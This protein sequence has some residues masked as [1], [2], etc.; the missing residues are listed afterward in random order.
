MQGSIALQR[1]AHLL[2]TP[3]SLHF[4]KPV[5]TC[6]TFF[7]PQE[8]TGA[9]PNAS[10]MTTVFRHLPLAPFLQILGKILEPDRTR[11]SQVEHQT[12]GF[13]KFGREISAFLQ[14]QIKKRMVE[15]CRKSNERQ[16]FQNQAQLTSNAFIIHQRRERERAN[17]IFRKCFG[18]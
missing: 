6:G 14:R 10:S 16:K 18:D 15:T 2:K 7:Q 13:G 9:M 5:E 11:P 12:M 3:S 4:L 17:S 8:R 1:R